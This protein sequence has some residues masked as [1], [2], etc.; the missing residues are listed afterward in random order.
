MEKERFQEI[1]GQVAEIHERNMDCGGDDLSSF[2]MC[3][4][5]GLSPWKAVLATMATTMG[6]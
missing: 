4:K 6:G 3:E 1:L 5:M 2:K